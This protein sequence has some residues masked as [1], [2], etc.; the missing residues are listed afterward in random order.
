[1]AASPF[2]LEVSDTRPDEVSPRRGP[3]WR[4]TEAML[5]R[6]LRHSSQPGWR[7]PRRPCWPALVDRV[8]HDHR[9]LA[10]GLA[11]I[12]GIGGPE[13]QRLVPEARPFRAGGGSRSRLKLPGP[14]LN[15]DYRVGQ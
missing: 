4:Q 6:E 1:M 8:Q 10:L 9:D 3:E 5:R 12:V 7:R 14:D 11:L 13:L 2:G 15:L